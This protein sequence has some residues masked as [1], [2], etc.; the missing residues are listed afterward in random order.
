MSTKKSETAQKSEVRIAITDVARELSFECPL[1]A[2]E[3][4][5]AVDHALST[6]S[7]LVLSDIRGRE[8]IVPADKIGFVEIGD[9]A[10]RRVGFANA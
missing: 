10:E 6:Q 2:A 7:A 9:Q 3:I 5:S 4:R 1:T 8:I